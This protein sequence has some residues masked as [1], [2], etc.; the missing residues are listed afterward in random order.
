MPS[1]RV[2]AWAVLLVFLVTGVCGDDVPAETAAQPTLTELVVGF[3]RS[4][5][6]G[7]RTA[8]IKSIEEVAGGDLNL[9]I[10]AIETAKLWPALKGEDGTFTFDS[11]TFGPISVAYRLPPAYDPARPH[12][13]MIC[14]PRNGGSPHTTLAFASIICGDA[15]RDHVLLSPAG[16]IGGSFHQP[17]AAAAD[18]PALLRE[19]RRRIH[20]DANRVFLFGS[21]AGADAAWM[22]AIMH[23]DLF[24]GAITMSGYP[25]VPYPEQAYPFLLENLR[26]LA[27]LAVWVSPD[28]SQATARDKVVGHHNRAII[29]FAKRTSLPIIGIETPHVGA[30]ALKPPAD[31][32]L[33]LLDRRRPSRAD[34]V[35]HWF[36]YPGQGHAGWLR[37]MRFLRDVWEGEQ[38]SIL[39]S[40]T[41]DRNEFITEVIQGKMAYLGGWVEG[42]TVEIE[43]HNCARIELLLPAGLVDFDRPIT[44]RCNGKKRYSGMLRPN[45][46]TLLE[47]AYDRWEFQRPPVARLSFSIKSDHKHK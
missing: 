7:Q 37:Q 1:C 23:A 14:M 8:I 5:D 11:N 15:L 13:L 22:A 17:A 12:P 18:L 26:Q 3:F 38:L 31:A 4:E 30:L 21:G 32:L 33:H 45:I 44:V 28:D 29:R 20:I 36:R 2:A 43:T 27:V 39:P 42:Q 46:R 25:R 9:V 34:S 10:D 19:A 40:P 35:S 41:T 24:A 47:T 6:P 16:R